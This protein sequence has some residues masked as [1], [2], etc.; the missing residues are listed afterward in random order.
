MPRDAR[1][2]MSLRTEFV[3]FAS[4]DGANIREQCRRYGIS[5]ATGC[6]GFAA[7]RRKDRPAFRTAPAP[8]HS[9]SRSSDITDLLRMAHEQHQ[10]GARKIKRWLEDR[11][12]ACRPYRPQPDGPPRLVAGRSGRPATAAG[13]SM[14]PRT[15]SGRWILR[16]TF[17]L[18]AAAATRL[19]CW[20]TTR[21]S[22]CTA[23]TNG[24]DGTGAAGQRL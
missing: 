23:L 21:F 18:A 10:L 8:R 9:P 12:T 5:P 24:G 4:Q 17:P 14:R 7:G 3:L 6:C 2:T 13:L 15:G 16:A 20:T 1:D 11:G 22:L 19:P